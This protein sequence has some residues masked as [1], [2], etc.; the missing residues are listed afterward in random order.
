MKHFIAQEA[1]AYVSNATQ[2][3]AIDGPAG[4]GKS[5]IARAVART[6]NFAFLDTG[7]MYRAATWW[8]QQCAIDPQD[9]AAVVQAVSTMPF[10]MEPFADG[11]RVWVNELEVTE[12]IRRPEVTRMISRIDHYPAMRK[13]LVTMQQRFGEQQPT[14]AEGRDIGTVVFPNARCK[15]YMDA[16]PEERARRRALEMREKGLAVD[17][18]AL[19]QEIR[20]RDEDNMT[21]TES[22]LRQADDAL[23]L[24][25]TGKSFEV[26]LDEVLGYA[27]ERLELC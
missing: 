12:E 11:L 9:E 6:L 18:A 19:L 1:Q 24:D 27:R 3:I 8:V 22:P 10:R 7:A 21:R 15:I 14:V 16:A 26:V 4:A 25:T 5:S 2:I 13:H 23:R 17:E 20:Q